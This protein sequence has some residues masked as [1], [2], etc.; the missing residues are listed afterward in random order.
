MHIISLENVLHI[1]QE[2]NLNMKVKKN[3]FKL[4]NRKRGKKEIKVESFCMKDITKHI[5]Q[6]CGKKGT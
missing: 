1:E 6:R 2:I 5:I 4:N 3:Y